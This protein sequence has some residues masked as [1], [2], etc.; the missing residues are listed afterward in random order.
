MGIQIVGRTDSNAE[1]KRHLLKMNTRLD[2]NYSADDVSTSSEIVTK[3]NV[4]SV[5]W[6]DTEITRMIQITVRPILIIVGT[7]GNCL[8][9]YIMRRTSLK[10]L[11]SCFYMSLLALAD[12]RKYKM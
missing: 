11:S 4:D 8:T 12:T 1:F 2:L 5:L 7:I 9:F 3:T 10:E 6:V